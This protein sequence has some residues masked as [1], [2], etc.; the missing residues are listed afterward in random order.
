MAQIYYIPPASADLQWE[1]QLQVGGQRVS[2]FGHTQRQAMLAVFSAASP[3]VQAL[4]DAA[5]AEHE[6]GRR[7]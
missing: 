2:A 4:K 5:Q 3:V 6:R 7:K 1:A